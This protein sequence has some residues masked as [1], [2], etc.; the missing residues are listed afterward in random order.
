MRVDIDDLLLDGFSR[1]RDLVPDVVAGLD[2]DTLAVRPDGKGNSIAWL[3]WH[4]TRV[5]DD[6]VA[7]VAGTDQVWLTDGWRE[8]FALALPER[9]TGYGHAT[10]EVVQ[11]RAAPDLLTEYHA[12]VAART[13]QF[14]TGL[15]AADLDRVVD[16]RWSPPVTLGVRLV[17]VM[18]DCMQHIGQASYVRGL[19]V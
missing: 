18:D 11:V 17:S 6:H 7:D 3:V 9:D 2:T 8:R 5:Q 16:E 13:E 12:A 19:L 10:D 15:R 14:V 4:L 1:V